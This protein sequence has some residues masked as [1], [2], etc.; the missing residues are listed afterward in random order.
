MSNNT[1]NNG[2]LIKPPNIVKFLFGGAAGMGATMFVQP[3]D[4]IKNRMQVSKT[5]VGFFPT[6]ANVVKADGF[7]GLYSGLSAGLL[8]QATYTTTRLGVYTTL[9]DHLTKDGHE[10]SFPEMAAVGMCAGAI[11]ATIGTPSE[12]ALIRMSA[13]GSLPLA[14]RRNYTSAFNAI[15][16]IAREEGVLALWRGCTPTVG[17]AMVVNAAQLAT[18]SRAKQFIGNHTELTG[19]PLH[20]SA[21]MVSGLATT[22]ASMPVD[23]LKTRLQNMKYINGVPEYKGALDVAMTIVRKEGVLSLWKGFIPYYTRLGPHTVITFIL[24]EQMNAAYSRFK[25][26]EAI[27]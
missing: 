15:F 4:L 21:S 2:K 3:F 13:D 17:R 19:I 22:I 18:Y 11:G 5:G 25:K 23:I 8:R 27:V 10:L 1:G 6:I 9:F 12:I 7:T 24:L 26:G 16:R 14:E 20:F